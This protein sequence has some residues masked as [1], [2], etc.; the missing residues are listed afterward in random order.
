MSR[1]PARPPAVAATGIFGR[2]SEITRV[3]N[4]SRAARN[5]NFSNWRRNAGSRAISQKSPITGPGRYSLP[6]KP[7][8]AEGRY[9]IRFFS[10]ASTASRYCSV[11]RY[12]VLSLIRI[13]RSFVILPLSTMSTHTF[14][15]V[16]AKVTRSGVPSIL[17]R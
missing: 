7:Q 4:D 15:T 5:S 13:A 1:A 12:G 6:A 10:S 11:V 17:P 16:S 14:S 3:L 8:A 2:T 9:P